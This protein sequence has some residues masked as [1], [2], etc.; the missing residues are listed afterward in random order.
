MDPK[1]KGTVPPQ[2]ALVISPGGTTAIKG[3]NGKYTAK[4]SPGSQLDNDYF[5]DEVVVKISSLTA[6]RIAGTFSG[7][8][9][10]SS[11]T[12]NI[13]DGQFDLP[14]SSYSQPLK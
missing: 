8:F 11:I 1:Y 6:T 14:K 9:S 2:I 13:T 7:K 4:Y 5:G 12:I 10:S 3:N